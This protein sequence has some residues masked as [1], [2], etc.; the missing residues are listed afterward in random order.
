MTN[1]NKFERGHQQ[2]T[3]T[4]KTLN[5]EFDIILETLPETIGLVSEY[6]KKGSITK[7]TFTLDY[8]SMF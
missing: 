1:L 5:L 6:L 3:T 7:F 2:I 8:F 4:S